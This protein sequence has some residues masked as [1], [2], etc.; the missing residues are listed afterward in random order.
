MWL[1]QTTD[2]SY[3]DDVIKHAFAGHFV[4]MEQLDV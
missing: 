3:A 4:D 1:L 2:S